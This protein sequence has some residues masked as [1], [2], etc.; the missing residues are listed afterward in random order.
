MT[1]RPEGKPAGR[2]AGS[3]F[4]RG[5]RWFFLIWAS[6]STL[7]LVDTFRTRGVDPELLRSDSSVAVTSDQASL[8]FLPIGRIKSSGLVFI[9]GAG[10]SAE[11]YAP[12]LRP[13]A[14]Q[15]HPVVV[16]RLPFRIAPLAIHKQTVIDRAVA[17]TRRIE[18]VRRWV[19]AGHSL[20]G[21]LAARAVKQHP[22]TFSAA[23]LVAT[24]HPR[25]DDLSQSKVPFTK[26][27]ASEDGVARPEAVEATRDR[28][29][30]DTRW[31]EIQGGNH[32]QFGNYGHQL[33]DGKAS[34]SRAEQQEI[35]RKILLDALTLS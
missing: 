18:R 3:A 19:I 10:V 23:V 15:G 29:P 17:T 21:K 6:L 4:H 27:F 7:W 33:F 9:S 12:L 16:I 8:A 5:L 25:E 2:S 34:I 31:V 1:R 28:L 22:A 20:G 14:E 32:S 11:A 26:I 35:V 13:I 24:S 30:A